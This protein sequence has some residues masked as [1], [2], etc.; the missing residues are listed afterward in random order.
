MDKKELWVGYTRDAAARY[1]VPDEVDDADDLVDDMT[2]VVTKYADEMLDQFES[3]EEDGFFEQE[4]SA[5]RP[6][7]RKRKPK[8]ETED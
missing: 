6:R 2:S 5:P 3:R 8:T 4:S 7:T 1:V